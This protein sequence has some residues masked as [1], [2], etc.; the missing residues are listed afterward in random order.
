RM[1]LLH[2]LRPHRLVLQMIKAAVIADR[3]LGPQRLD[4]L[5][6]LAEA[7][8]PARDRHLELPVMMLAADADPE[9]RAPVADVI[10][11]APLMGD[12]QRAVDLQDDDRAADADSAR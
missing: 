6:L 4:D 7:A 1:R 8:D 9:D 10:E 5:K 2:R 11:T 12:H 3:V